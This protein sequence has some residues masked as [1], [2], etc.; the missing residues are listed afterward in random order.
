MALPVLN[1]VG[2]VS[3]IYASLSS[4]LISLAIVQEEQRPLRTLSQNWNWTWKRGLLLRSMKRHKH[5]RGKWF[6][7]VALL[8]VAPQIR[9]WKMVRFG[10]APICGATNTLVENGSFQSR[11]YLWRHK[12]ARGKWFAS[13]ALLFVAPQTRSWKVVR[14]SRALFVAPQ[15]RSC[16]GALRVLVPRGSGAR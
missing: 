16:K 10:R 8:F 3:R 1:W 2:N 9:S 5:S 4:S 7:S 14:F 11:S 12:H 13:V 15:T 6:A